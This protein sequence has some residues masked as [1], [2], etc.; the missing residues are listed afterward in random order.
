MPRHEEVTGLSVT[1]PVPSQSTSILLVWLYYKHQGIRLE[2]RQSRM[3]QQTG[4]GQKNPLDVLPTMLHA[5]FI[6]TA[7][8]FNDPRKHN[9]RAVVTTNAKIR[10]GIPIAIDRFQYALDCLE[11]DILRA[12]SILRR[13]LEVL[14][15]RREEAQANAE[16]ECGHLEEESSGKGQ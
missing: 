2:L 1:R 10:V 14:R 15:Q 13:D 6:Q 4:A 16:R 5:V 12:K 8:V 7:H 9:P 3:P 11:A